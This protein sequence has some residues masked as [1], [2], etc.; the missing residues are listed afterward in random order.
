M[1]EKL[2]DDSEFEMDSEEFAEALKFRAPYDYRPG[3][4]S[5]YGLNGRLKDE[6]GA[7]YYGSSFREIQKACYDKYKTNPQVFTAIK[8][9]VGRMVGEGFS[10]GS[11]VFEINEFMQTIWEDPR[12]RLN[13]MMPKYVARAKAEGELFLVLTLHEDGFVEI[14]F[15]YPDTVKGLG[16]VGNS[17]GSGILYHPTKPSMPLLYMFETSYSGSTIKEQIPSIFVARYPELMDIVKKD[18]AVN[19][20]HLKSS[21]SS[22]AKFKKT[23]GFYRFVIQWDMADIESRNVSQ[24]QTTLFWVNMYETL[25]MFEIEHK[26]SSGSYL[27]A[28][29]FEDQNAFRQWLKL[30]DDERRKT[31]IMAKKVP[32]GS[33]VLPPGVKIEV[34]NPQLPKISDSDTDIMQ[35]IVSGLNVP[36][37]MALGTNK[38]TFASVKASRGPMTDRVSDELAYFE[39][40]LRWDFWDSIFFLTSKV[41]SFKYEHTV[42]KAVSYKNKKPVFKTFKEKACKLVELTFPVSESTDAEARARAYFGVKHGSLNA[43]LGIP[44]S[45]L[46][47]KLGFGNYAKLRLEAATEE[48][49]YPELQPE[50]D[51]E[52][53]TQE[54]AQEKQAGSG[55]SKKPVLKKRVKAE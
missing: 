1:S 35:M 50:I 31:G 16:S 27:W 53:T 30:S 54:R 15:R 40:F 48:D 36:E 34:K 14:D 7:S 39:R 12:N 26:R 9:M 20:E 37:D 23:G 21:K 10:C 43:T 17:D 41:S 13:L 44:N 33:L 24:V 49:L 52:G 51:Q 2:V 22:K 18:P 47:K 45:V 19:L 25:K 6:D 8:D 29:S 3:G 5:S 4:S 42:R 32:G 38:G 46:A 55:E 11:G 28:F